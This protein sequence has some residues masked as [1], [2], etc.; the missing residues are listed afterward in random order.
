MMMRRAAILIAMIAL[1]LSSPAHM[2]AGPGQAPVAVDDPRLATLPE[3]LRDRGRAILAAVDEEERGD[4]AEALAEDDAV[5]A[6]D[7]LLALLDS[8]PSA[9]VRE[10]IVDSLEE[11]ADDRVTSAL[12]RRLLTDADID[13]AL[14]SLDLLRARAVRPLLGLLE[15]RL[16]TESK[17]GGGR[18][19]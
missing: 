7:F 19:D 2:W 15:E 10:E 17:G 16:R 1:G 4:L 12:E 13:I 3:S 8:D 18:G 9:D 14:M 6:L 11:V 5:A